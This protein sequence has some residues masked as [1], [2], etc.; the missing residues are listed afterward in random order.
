MSEGPL[1]FS[2][3]ALSQE[4]QAISVGHIFSSNDDL[5]KPRLVPV[6]IRILLDH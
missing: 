3:I 1:E 4:L 5:I 6:A 2:G